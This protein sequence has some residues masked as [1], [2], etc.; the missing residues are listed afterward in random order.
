M[1]NSSLPYELSVL[2]A[3]VDPIL[4]TVPEESP[5]YGE[6]QRLLFML[7]FIPMIPSE[8]IPNNSILREFIDGTCFSI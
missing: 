6:A 1:F 8:D 7:K 5:V 3:Y 4:H 2:R